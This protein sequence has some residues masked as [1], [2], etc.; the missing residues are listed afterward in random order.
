[1]A[2]ENKTIEETCSAG[3]CTGC[4][5]CVALCPNSAIKMI[6]SEGVYVPQLNGEKCNQCGICYEACPGHSVDFKELNLAMFGREA[7]DILRG[8]YVNCYIGHAADPS[9]RYKSASGGLVT[10]L[11]IFAIEEGIIDG[12]LITKMSDKNPLEPEVFIT[13]SREEIIS[14]SKSK[15]CPV[16]ANIAIKEILKQDGKFA[17]VG[18]PCH[19][20][21]IRK[22]E[23]L[24]K[25]LRKIVLHLGLMCN[26]APTF[27]ATEYLLQKMNVGKED[28]KKIDYR[29]EG[30]PGG[31]SITLKNEERIF[32]PMFSNLYW[33]AVFQSYFIPIRCA[34]C[35]DKI[36]ELSDISFG[37][38]WLP[39]LSGDRLG[40]SIIVSRNRVSEELLQN[41]ISKKK[42]ELYETDSDK[43]LQSQGLRS[44]KKRI[45][46]RISVFNGLSKKVPIYNQKLLESDLFDYIGAFSLYLQIH[47]SSKQSLWVLLDPYLFLLRCANYLKSKLSSHAET[48]IPHQ[49]AE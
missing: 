29:G 6:R 12:A 49:S 25:K 23:M 2:I 26:H 18:L 10:A 33:G 5:T 39:E 34:L 7:E 47:I 30:W 24:N 1:M 4:G 8:N 9:I 31:M 22:A 32:I 27:S 13:R 43:V 21:G 3:L 44:V 14:A 19:I 40:E 41:A 36:C 37:D 35:S 20:H 15:Y 45:N 28:V 17:V 38:A 42:I 46:A 16:P 11:L 48:S